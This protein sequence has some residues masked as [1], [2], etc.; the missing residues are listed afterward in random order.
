MSFFNPFSRLFRL[1]IKKING[2]FASFYLRNKKIQEQLINFSTGGTMRWTIPI[3][4]F[5]KLVTY[6]PNLKEQQKI[7]NFLDCYMKEYNQKQESLSHLKATLKIQKDYILQEM[8]TVN[9]GGAPNLRFKEFNDEWKNENIN[10]FFKIN[11]GNNYKNIIQKNGEF[12][13]YSSKIS[14]YG[15]IGYSNKFNYFNACLTFTTRGI[16]CGTLFYREKHKFWA[17]HMCGILTLNNKKNITKFFYF[18]LKNM[19]FIST[20]SAQPQIT[21]STIKLIKIYINERKYK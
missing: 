10:N 7:A 14:N 5:K 8:L 4:S 12:P 11:F 19:L 16:N 6:I 17:S 18:L 21:K 13:I 3:N 15:I 9:D 1:D 2:K 20:G